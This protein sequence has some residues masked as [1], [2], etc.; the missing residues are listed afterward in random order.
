MLIDRSLQLF[1]MAHQSLLFTGW[2][3]SR[4]SSVSLARLRFA[5]VFSLMVIL[6]FLWLIISLYA[7]AWEM[8]DNFAPF[9]LNS[10]VAMKNVLVWFP[11]LKPLVVS[12]LASSLP[13]MFTWPLTH[14]KEVHPPLFLSLFTIGLIILAC[15]TFTKFEL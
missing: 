9:I 5:M 11:D 6:H 10:G 12:L 14:S 1:E 2:V 13:S 4:L 3:F 7:V 15:A 8:E